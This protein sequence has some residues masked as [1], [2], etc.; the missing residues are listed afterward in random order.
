MKASS[1]NSGSSV[2][3]LESHQ[4]LSGIAPLAGNTTFTL[5]NGDAYGNITYTTNKVYQI[6]GMGI[7]ETP[8]YYHTTVT[9][10]GIFL[11]K[12]ITYG[13]ADASPSA[14]EDF[15]ILNSESMGSYIFKASG[16]L[17]ITVTSVSGGTDPATDSNK[18]LY[19]RLVE[20]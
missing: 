12:L 2:S 9:V 20:L 1:S 19:F 6:T 7:S 13:A 11:G 16:S 5:N 10:N 14:A 4:T 17:V 8:N 15:F 18:I 3:G